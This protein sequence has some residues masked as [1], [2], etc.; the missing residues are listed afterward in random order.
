MLNTTARA[1]KGKQNTGRLN[2]GVTEKIKARAWRN[3]SKRCWG[4]DKD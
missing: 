4:K 1:Q 3:K 2:E